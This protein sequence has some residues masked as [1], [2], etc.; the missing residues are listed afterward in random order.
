VAQQLRLLA[1]SHHPQG[2]ASSSLK[3]QLQEDQKP[4]LASG[5]TRTRTAHISVVPYLPYSASPGLCVE[6]SGLRERADGLWKPSSQECCGRKKR[7]VPNRGM[8][9]P[10]SGWRRSWASKEVAFSVE[11]A[12]KVPGCKND[13]ALRVRGELKPKHSG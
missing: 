6:V 7:M 5:A 10:G 9:K 2:S 11:K 4:L 3:L 1:G 8:R 12:R 13:R